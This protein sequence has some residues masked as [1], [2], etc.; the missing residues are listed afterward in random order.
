MYLRYLRHLGIALLIQALWT[1][2]SYTPLPANRRVVSLTR[3]A[4]IRTAA[5]AG[6][7]TEKDDTD[8]VPAI[9]YTQ[10]KSDDPRFLDMPWPTE[11]GPES[12]AFARHMQWK[13]RLSDGEREQHAQCTDDNGTAFARSNPCPLT[14]ST[15]LFPFSSM[16]LS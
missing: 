4:L 6:M 16:L 15:L 2:L 12:A 10:L 8:P 14:T 7:G 11:A 1:A 3:A 9:D 13:R 5:Q